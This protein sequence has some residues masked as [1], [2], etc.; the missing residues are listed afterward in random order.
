[1]KYIIYIGIAVFLLFMFFGPS[2]VDLAIDNPT[3]RALTVS[4]DDLHVDVPPNEVIWVEMG[5]GE[6][7]ITLED[8]SEHPY[9]FEKRAYMLNPTMSEYLV[10]ESFFGTEASRVEYELKSPKKTVE[11]M[12]IEFEGNYDV[13]NELISE[14]TWDI[15]AR[16]A[17]PMSVE[18]DADATYVVIKKLMSTPEFYAQI[19][20]SLQETVEQ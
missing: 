12:G 5:K 3:E 8:G 19:R 15:G 18:A 6:H 9:N 16:E 4:V 17:V 20:E 13:V 1:M 10:T 11:F 14:V 7:V 2:S